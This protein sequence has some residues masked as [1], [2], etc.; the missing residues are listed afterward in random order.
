[1]RILRFLVVSF[2]V[3]SILSGVAFVVIRE[4]LLF[5]AGSQVR[6]SLTV[7]RRSTNLVPGTPAPECQSASSLQGGG[8][9]VNLYA[10]QLAFQDDRDF[11]W[12]M[13]CDSPLREPTVLA[14]FALPPF[15]KKV[16]GSG[17]LLWREPYSTFSIEIW[18][19]NKSF[20]LKDRDL[21]VS[22]GL[23]PDASPKQPVTACAGLGY[24]C[25]GLEAEVGAGAQATLVRDCPLS[26][27]AQCLSRP[28]ILSLTT[29]PYP[30]LATR[31]VTVPG[32]QEISF[33]Y[34]VDFGSE[35][36][37]QVTLEFGDG[38]QYQSTNAQDT[39][40]HVYRCGGAC[41]FQA[42]LSIVDDRGSSSA[43]SSINGLQIR[44][45][46]R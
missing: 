16:P 1:M 41:T 43:E 18:G 6:S 42:R 23:V 11:R 39:V 37:G 17:G 5:V 33:T 34:L 10:L 32:G 3:L 45:T 22:N 25:C 20:V 30:D 40:A 44:V 7:V 15:V 2:V 13:I 24:H 35:R 4:A 8:G 19:R 26:C 21:S 27:Y 31:S 46:G 9:L 38:E 12:E 28:V 29:Q 36:T 14:E